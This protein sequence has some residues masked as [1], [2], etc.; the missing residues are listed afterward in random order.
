MHPT[1]TIAFEQAE[2]GVL[3][4]VDPALRTHDNPRRVCFQVLGV[5][6][7]TNIRHLERTLTRRLSELARRTAI[8]FEELV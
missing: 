7:G 4:P 8:E 1:M 2:N 5:P 3:A 6:T